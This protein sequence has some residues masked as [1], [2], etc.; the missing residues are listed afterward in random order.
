MPEVQM[1]EITCPKCGKKHSFSVWDSINVMEHPDMREK[2][3]NDEA[4]RFQCPDCGASALLNYNFLYHD[5]EEKIFIFCNAEQ[6]ACDEIRRVLTDENNAFKNYTKRI[7]PS[8]NAF[9]E[10]LMIFDEGLDDRVIEWMKVFAFTSL[11]D[12]KPELRPERVLFDK[13]TDGNHYFRFG[14][15][16]RT[17][18]AYAFERSLY[19]KIKNQWHDEINDLSENRPVINAEWAVKTLAAVQN[20]E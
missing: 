2:V 19:N 15:K 5:P 12:K 3:R 7:V 4:F 16:D 6:T 18:A 20:R 1:Q 14:E 10:K 11:R 17:V 9:K 8:Y 13:G